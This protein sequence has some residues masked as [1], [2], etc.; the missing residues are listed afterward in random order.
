MSDKCQACGIK[1]DQYLP[2]VI[3]IEG[4]SPPYK[5]CNNCVEQLVNHRLRPQQYRSLIKAGHTSTEYY[6]N[7]GF[8]TDEGFPLQPK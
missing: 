4:T 6:L 3:V 2:G 8:Y 5:L 7:D 1:F